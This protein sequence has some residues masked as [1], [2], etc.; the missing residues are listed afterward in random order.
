MKIDE[1]LLINPDAD[2]EIKSFLESVSAGI[3]S[4]IEGQLEKVVSLSE[5]FTRNPNKTYLARVSGD[6][7]IQAGINE[8]DTLI[9]DCEIEPKN[10]SVIVAALAG[11]LTVKYYLRQQDRVFLCAANPRYRDIEVLPY[12]NF[13]CLG[14]VLY[15]IKPHFF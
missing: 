8:G 7:M 3:P 15:S 2:L 4:H 11:E 6:S 9:V 1:I 13:E 14:V 12:M 10:G 5:R